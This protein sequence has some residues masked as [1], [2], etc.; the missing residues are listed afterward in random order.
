[1]FKHL[2]QSMNEALAQIAEKLP[3]SKETERQELIEQWETLRAISDEM[4]EEWL[5]FEEKMA[6]LNLRSELGLPKAKPALAP[7][8]FDPTGYEA[9]DDDPTGSGAYQRG[10]GYFKLMMFPEAVREFEQVVL[11]HP[12]CLPAR[13]YLALGLLQNESIPEAY[14][15]LLIIISLSEESRL[16]AVAYNALGCVQ[17]MNGNVEKACEC[18]RLSHHLDPGLKDPVLNLQACQTNSGVLQLGVAIG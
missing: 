12:E 7:L 5:L 18:F 13:L 10:E 1:M 2:F 14:G 16:K 17:A 6:K 11:C 15:H 8:S 3:L 4:I 9:L